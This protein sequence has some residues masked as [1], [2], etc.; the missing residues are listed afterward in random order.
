MAAA[1]TLTLA[2]AISAAA[3]V[4][5]ATTSAAS[6]NGAAASLTAFDHRQV[7]A[8]TVRTAGATAAA[9]SHAREVA[10]GSWR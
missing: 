10:A 8:H 5:P 4:L 3:A 9:Q 6:S 1:G 7:T 2:T